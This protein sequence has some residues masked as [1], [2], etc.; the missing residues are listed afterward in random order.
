MK[1]HSN[2]EGERSKEAPP[3]PAMLFTVVCNED[4][5]TI[6]FIYFFFFTPDWGLEEKGKRHVINVIV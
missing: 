6:I 5:Y 1:G 2:E 3:P 4:I